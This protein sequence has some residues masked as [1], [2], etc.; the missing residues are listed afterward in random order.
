MILKTNLKEYRIKQGL[1]QSELAELVSVRRE[2][3][4]HLERGEY[5]PS[6]KLAYD[7]AKVFGATI[8][9]LFWYGEDGQDEE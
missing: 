3:I 9:E 7:I 8:E 2:T 6:L 5:N 4:G 1:S